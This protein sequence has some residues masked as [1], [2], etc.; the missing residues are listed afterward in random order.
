MRGEDGAN[1]L[2]IAVESA[3]EM[4]HFAGIIYR[5]AAPAL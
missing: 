4:S 3:I 5:G 1:T 2:L